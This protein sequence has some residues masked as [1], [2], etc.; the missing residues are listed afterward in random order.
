M[1]FLT[2]NKYGIP[3]HGWWIWIFSATS[4]AYAREPRDS[5]D[6]H[7]STHIQSESSASSNN[8]EVETTK[9]CGSPFSV[10]AEKLHKAI[11]NCTAIINSLAATCGPFCLVSYCSS[12]RKM[13]QKHLQVHSFYLF[14][15]KFKNQKISRFQNQLFFYIILVNTCFFPAGKGYPLWSFQKAILNCTARINS[16]A[17]QN[18]KTKKT[19]KQ[20]LTENFW[21]R[22]QRWFFLVFLEFFCFFVLKCQNQETTCVFL[23]FCI[24]WK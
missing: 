13:K 1:G 2:W 7:S 18:Q 4:S 12:K 19:K 24:L 6:V 10:T 16:L 21:F 14:P 3:K 8:P 22:A 17:K 9:S 5:R 15:K 23:I 20:N 11:V